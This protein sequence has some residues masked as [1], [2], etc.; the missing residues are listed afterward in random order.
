MF[1]RLSWTGLHTST[2]LDA[3]IDV[4][5]GRLA[6]HQLVDLGGAHVDA[7]PRPYALVVIDLYR[8]SE[9]VALILLDRQVPTVRANARPAIIRFPRLMTSSADCERAFMRMFID[10]EVFPLLRRG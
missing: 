8:E 6:V 9:G 1:Y 3:F 10:A 2:A 5:S 7:L 4:R